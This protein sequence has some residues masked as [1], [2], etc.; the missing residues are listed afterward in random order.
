MEK[1]TNKNVENQ[2]PKKSPLKGSLAKDLE[3]LQDLTT[4]KNPLSEPKS[5]PGTTNG[6]QDEQD[7]TDENA[8]TPII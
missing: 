4:R 6:K 2:T 1:S 8:G 3:K 5:K 7:P